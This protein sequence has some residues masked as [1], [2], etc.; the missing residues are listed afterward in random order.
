LFFAVC[1]SAIVL[2]V[3]DVPLHVAQKMLQYDPARR[4]SA[5][6][7]MDHAFFADLP[8]TTLVG[9][10][11]AGTNLSPTSVLGGGMAVDST[12]A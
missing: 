7:A 11:A 9:R 10:R 4:I 6:D 5:R 2:V 1:G 8:K 3:T 12:V